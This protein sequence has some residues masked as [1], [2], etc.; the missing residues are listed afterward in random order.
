[1]EGGGAEQ[2]RQR[3]GVRDELAREVVEENRT[4]RVRASVG[5][6]LRLPLVVMGEVAPDAI[7]REGFGE[8]ALVAGHGTHEPRLKA[9]EPIGEHESRQTEGERS[10]WP[11]RRRVTN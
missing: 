6:K 9:L 4:G 1:G 11:A 10:E 7:D 3:S 5:S 2:Q 8:I